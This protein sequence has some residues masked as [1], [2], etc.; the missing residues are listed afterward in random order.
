[1]LEERDKLIGSN[2]YYVTQ[3]GAGKGRQ[4]LSRLVKVLGP[5]VAHI[6]SD[7]KPGAA[8]SALS[9]VSGD[10]LKGAL[11]ELS[12]RISEADINYFCETF[13]QFSKVDTG[14]GKRPQM[15]LEFQNLHFAGKYG[16]MMQWLA[17]AAEV[18]FSDFFGV[19]GA[20]GGAPEA[21]T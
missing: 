7:A 13:G 2:R 12:E 16:E 1:M 6:V 9:R 18:N 8:A 4:A 10:A 15:S 14:D 5:V 19:L 3:L 11:L 20:S 21:A 17:F